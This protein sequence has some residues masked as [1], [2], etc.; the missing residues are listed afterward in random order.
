[1]AAAGE[2]LVGGK[3]EGLG[4]VLVPALADQLGLDRHRRGGQRR[5]PGSGLPGGGR[6]DGPAPAQ[7]AVQ[8]TQRVAR[9]RAGFQLLLLQ[10]ELQARRVIPG[11][12]Q[13]RACDRPGLP[14]GRVD[15]QEFFFDAHAARIHRRTMPADQASNHIAT[16]SA[17][18]LMWM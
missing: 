9:L 12:L 16:A 6:G 7:L 8:I 13:R 15:Q 10:L 5:H 17:S 14:A 3:P 2:L 1:M 11:R 4:H 18:W